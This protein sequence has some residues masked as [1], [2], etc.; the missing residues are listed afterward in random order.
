MEEET[1]GWFETRRDDGEGTGQGRAETRVAFMR[2][3]LVTCPP[4]RRDR[5]SGGRSRRLGRKDDTLAVRVVLLT[6]MVGL[7]SQFQ[8]HTICFGPTRTSQKLFVLSIMIIILK[9]NR[10][11][12]STPM[13]IIPVIDTYSFSDERGG[14]L[15]AHATTM[16]RASIAGGVCQSLI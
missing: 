1:H 6:T 12:D 2:Q 5:R 9:C 16:D 7:V 8:L 3:F 13:P 11:P 15:T 4:N 14:L 10:F